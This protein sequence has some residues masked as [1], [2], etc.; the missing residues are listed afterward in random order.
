MSFHLLP[1]IFNKDTLFRLPKSIREMEDWENETKDQGLTIYDDENNN[2]VVEAAMP[3]LKNEEIDIHLDKGVLWIKGHQKTEEKENKKFY[4]KSI[5]SFS[6]SITLPDQIE[7][8]QQPEASYKNGIL[9]IAFQRAR[10]SKA[11]RI[12]IKNENASS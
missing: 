3:G 11:Q 6:Y 5:R 4:K 8:N 1:S 9:K 2:I 7:E 10:A 12:S